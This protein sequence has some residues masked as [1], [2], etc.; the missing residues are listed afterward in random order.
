[1]P[2]GPATCIRDTPSSTGLS[3]PSSNSNHP[4]WRPC[5]LKKDG[6]LL[7][8]PAFLHF[9][10]CSS[11]P[12]AIMRRPAQSRTQRV[13]FISAPT[14]MTSILSGIAGVATSRKESVPYVIIKAPTTIFDQMVHVCMT[15]A[16]SMP[17]ISKMGV[18][19]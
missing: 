8:F 13:T 3:C 15:K 11:M 9:T 17:G 7:T 19:A 1:M 10:A 16:I 2:T 18:H 5:K 4:A 12:G 6:K 14:A